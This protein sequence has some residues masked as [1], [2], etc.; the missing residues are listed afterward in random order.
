LTDALIDRL[1]NYY[2]IAIRSNVGNLEAM[3]KAIQAS[4]MHCIASKR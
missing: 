3:K 2:G 1:Q 4:L